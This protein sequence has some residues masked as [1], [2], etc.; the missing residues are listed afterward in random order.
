[1]VVN[2]QDVFGEWCVC[3]CGDVVGDRDR[4]RRSQDPR[5][6]TIGAFPL[7]E[8]RDLA[9][10]DTVELSTS[11]VSFG[12]SRVR[13][14]IGEVDSDRGGTVCDRPGRVDRGELGT[15]RRFNLYRLGGQR[16][17]VGPGPGVERPG[18][19]ER[20]LEPDGRDVR[21]EEVTGCRVGVEVG[22]S[23]QEYVGR[24]GEVGRE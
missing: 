11:P 8:I 22:W 6:Y 17:R 4:D 14:I 24:A 7:N 13:G 5:D 9:T 18:V 15:T 3:V 16:I 23:R 20:E 1:M 19:G 21:W 12:S 2:R 10:G